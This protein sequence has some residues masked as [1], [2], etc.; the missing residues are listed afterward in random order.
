MQLLCILLYQSTLLTPCCDLSSPCWMFGG[1]RAVALSVC[2]SV[3]TLFLNTPACAL[4][5]LVCVPLRLLLLSLNTNRTCMLLSP[6]PHCLMRWC[7]RRSTSEVSSGRE[8]TPQRRSS[9][10]SSSTTASIRMV[11]LYTCWLAACRSWQCPGNNPSTSVSFLQLQDSVCCRGRQQCLH[12]LCL[13]ILAL[14]S[15]L[16]PLSWP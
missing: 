5:A 1:H 13:V 15:S 8:E 6:R 9:A 16:H 7:Q 12:G 3:T 11:L 4:P 2:Q 14:G 10:G